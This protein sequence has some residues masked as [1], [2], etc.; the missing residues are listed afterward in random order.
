MQD[1]KK[2]RVWHEAQRLALNVHHCLDAKKFAAYPGKRSQTFRCADSIASNIAEGSAKEG[3]EFARFLD[4]SLA[5]TTE[6]ESHL[7]FAGR[8]NLIPVRRH[9]RLMESVE[10]VRRMLIKF[11]RRVREGLDDQVSG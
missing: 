9:R 11:I 10:H 4:M 8:A 5:S 3:R 7:M 6:L 2:I 1:F